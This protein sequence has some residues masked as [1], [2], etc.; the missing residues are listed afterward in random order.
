MS[1]V[2]TTC[3]AEVMGYRSHHAHSWF[4]ER[5][6]S[7]GNWPE[8]T[9]WPQAYLPATGLHICIVGIGFNT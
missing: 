8:E 3:G 1:V 4:L 5:V 7:D 2:V 6:S 9:G